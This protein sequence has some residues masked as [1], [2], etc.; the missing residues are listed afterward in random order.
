MGLV[1]VLAVT[2]CP[3]ATNVN[4][5]GG[6]T[7]SKLQGGGSTFVAPIM[8][9][10]AKQYEKQKGLKVSYSGGGSGQGVANM[11]KKQYD[12]GCTDAYMTPQELDAAGGEVLHVPLIMGAA[13]PAYNLQGLPQAKPTGP[14]LADI[15]PGTVTKGNDKAVAD[16]NPG[17]PL[18]D[19]K[20]VPVRRSDPSGSTFILTTYLTQVSDEWKTAVGASTEVKWPTAASEGAKGTGALAKLVASTPG[21]IGYMELRYAT[22]NKL[23]YATLRNRKGKDVAGDKMEAVTAAAQ[24]L[25]KDIPDDLRF[26]LTNAD[27]DESYPLCGVVWAVLFADQQANKGQALKAFFGWVIKDGQQF[28]P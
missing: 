3:P 22:E 14:V 26:V 18:P 28:A 7:V 21:A 25:S 4:S 6:G 11:S 12:F 24:A 20:I 15:S 23:P 1:L 9:E 8:E 5:T 10:W 27:G 17:V 16:L 2:G 13:V 19:Q